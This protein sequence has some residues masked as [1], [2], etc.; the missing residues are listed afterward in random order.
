M[1]LGQKRFQEHGLEIECE[2]TAKGMA[3][4]NCHSTDLASP[5][6]TAERKTMQPLRMPAA[7]MPKICSSLIA[8]TR[9]G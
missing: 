3:G 7:P 8:A 5:A 1:A 4:G 2:E 9:M 6:R